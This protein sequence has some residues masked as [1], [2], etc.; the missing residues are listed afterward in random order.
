MEFDK[1]YLSIIEEILS[2]DKFI[3]LK[4]CEHHGISRF[5]HSIKV[6]YNAYKFAKKHQLD[7]KATA[8]GGLLHDFFDTK[9]Y[10]LKER[11]VSM[12]NHSN[13]ALINSQK[14]NISLKESNIIKSHMF[15]VNFYIPKYKE[16][17]IVNIIDKK[18]AFEEFISK[19]NYQFKYAYNLVLLLLFNFIK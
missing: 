10:T 15:P 6:S 9:N 4:N 8:I 7:Y 16:S 12:F 5:E 13:K 14:F 18:I 17:W 1:E 2:D 3:Q 11:L 19:F